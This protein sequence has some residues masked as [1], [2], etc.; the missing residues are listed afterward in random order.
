MITYSSGNHAQAVAYAAR[1]LGV[2]AVIVMP[3]TAPKIKIERT[4]TYGGEVLLEGTTSIERRRRAEHEAAQRGLAMIPPFDDPMVI[5]GQATV[6]R[7]ILEDAPDADRVYVPIGGGGLISGVAAAFKRAGASA[8]I[9]GVE[10]VGGACMTAALAAG[11][12]TTLE[13]TGSIADGLL[14]V[15][16]GDLTFEHVR[17]FVD[18]VVT[19]S[20]DAIARAVAWL[21][22]RCK[23]VVEPSGAATVAA[24]VDPA[25]R[26]ADREAR[27]TVAVVSGGNIASSTLCELLVGA[28]P[29]AR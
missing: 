22:E 2:S 11:H 25:A 1:A 15:R 14:P 21:F 6:G 4:I 8:R 10:P 20:D 16:A 5:A 12:P 19:V 26:D 29:P 23:L 17:A 13:T 18:E 24:A 9:I 3:T 28:T 27:E 7:E